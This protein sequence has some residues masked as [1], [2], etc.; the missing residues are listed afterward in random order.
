VYFEKCAIHR[1]VNTTI[2]SFKTIGAGLAYDSKNI[3]FN[4]IK[5]N[6][7]PKKIVI[8]YYDNYDN[9][10]ELYWLND[11]DLYKNN[12]KINKIDLESFQ[13]FKYSNYSKDKNNAY[14]AGEIIPGADPATFLYYNQLA[15]DSDA[16][17]KNTTRLRRNGFL[18]HVNEYF[19]KDDV[20]VYEY[21]YGHILNLKLLLDTNPKLC[22]NIKGTKYGVIHDS[23]YYW[24][25]K[26][27]IANINIDAI[28]AVDEEIITYNN[29][30]IYKGIITDKIDIN[31]LKIIQTDTGYSKIISDK[32]GIFKIS[33]SG[34]QVDI[35]K[36]DGVPEEQSYPYTY[37]DNNNTLI[38]F[39]EDSILK[40]NYP[41]DKKA[42]FTT[43]GI[44]NFNDIEVVSVLK[45][46]RPGCSQ[47]H[48]PGS[49][50]YIL[51]NSTGYWELKISSKNV[52][53]YIGK[54]YQF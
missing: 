51:K 36:L 45:G 24:K 47:D 22:R 10:N 23:L 32:N 43:K 33:T 50:Y 13:V 21:K 41:L 34:T 30:L 11:S 44:T 25:N 7:V 48:T 9:R 8:V 4:G 53:Q 2:A 52:L 16:V 3:F 38:T 5:L 1:K 31:T 18:K 37:F 14:Y 12:T 42:L 28:V 29:K 6:I 15:F 35:K 26:V 40:N 20:A 17:Y 39:N 19:F 49:N 27:N 46:Y 54:T